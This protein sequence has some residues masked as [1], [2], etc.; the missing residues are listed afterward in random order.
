MQSESRRLCRRGLWNAGVVGDP[1]DHC[2]RIGARGHDRGTLDHLSSRAVR[3]AEPDHQSADR[4]VL[5]ARSFR[6]LS[7]LG[8]GI[9]GFG[10]HD[11]GINS[12]GLTALGLTALGLTALGVYENSVT[13]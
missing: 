5:A 3:A 8:L 6:A 2:R 7:F 9:H 12:L 13:E 10:I 1:G 11:L 4:I